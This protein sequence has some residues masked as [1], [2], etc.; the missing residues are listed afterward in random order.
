MHQLVDIGPE[1]LFQD[2]KSTIF[3][4]TKV[5]STSER[6]RHIKIRYFFIHHYIQTKEIDLQYLPTAGMIADLLTKPLDGSLFTRLGGI[7]TGKLR[8]QLR[9]VKN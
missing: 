6:T 8:N 9:N 7:L 1:I 2:N 5:R 3:I 4:S